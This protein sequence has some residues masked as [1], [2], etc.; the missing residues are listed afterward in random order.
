MT[1]ARRLPQIV[2]VVAAVDWAIALSLLLTRTDTPVAAPLLILAATVMIMLQ[3]P[4]VR[5]MVG[6][7]RADRSRTRWAAVEAALGREWSP[8][9]ARLVLREP[10]LLWSVILLARGRRDGVPPAAGFGGY[11]DALPVWVVIGSV[12]VVE[13]AVTALLPLPAVVQRVLLVLGVWGAVLVLG[14]VAALVVHSHLVTNH[15]LVL[16]IGFWTEI[17]VPKDAVSRV[18]AAAGLG[19]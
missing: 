18:R 12:A 4:R 17:A 13:V 1:L 6:V 5:R 19:A 11:R 15:L 10:R 8:R 3:A 9:M 16:R 2:L 7:V 14:L